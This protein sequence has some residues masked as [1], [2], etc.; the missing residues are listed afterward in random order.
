MDVRRIVA[1]GSGGFSMEPRNGLLYEPL[2][3]GTPRV[4]AVLSA[5]PARKVD[6]QLTVLYGVTQWLQA[7]RGMSALEAGL[8]QLPM[9]AISA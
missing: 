3:S 4:R 1:M 2:A 7:G 5:Q 6:R 9:S 8:L